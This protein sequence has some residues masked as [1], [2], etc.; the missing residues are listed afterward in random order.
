MI[1]IL[2]CTVFVSA[3]VLSA[4]ALARAQQLHH[5]VRTEVDIFIDCEEK[6]ELR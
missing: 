6:L 3:S 2:T 5:E 1:R 4:A